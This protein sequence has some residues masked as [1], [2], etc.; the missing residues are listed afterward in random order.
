MEDVDHSTPSQ[1]SRDRLHKQHSLPSPSPKVGGGGGAGGGE[2]E[3]ELAAENAQLQARISVLAKV[4][5]SR[6]FGLLFC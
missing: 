2:K 5:L 6:G 4:S 1:S 3:Q